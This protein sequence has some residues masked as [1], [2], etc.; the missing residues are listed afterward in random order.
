MRKVLRSL[1]IIVLL[2]VLSAGSALAGGVIK[3]GA[4]VGGQVEIQ[5][6]VLGIVI[7][8]EKN[9]TETGISIGGEYFFDMNESLVVG[10]GVEYQLKRKNEGAEKGF[11]FVPLYVLGR[12]N[13]SPSFYFTGKVGYNLFQAEDLPEELKTKGG[14]F[15]GFGG[16]IIFADTLQLEILYSMNN[17]KIVLDEDIGVNYELIWNYSKIGVSIGYK[18]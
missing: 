12:Y 1:T 9:D 14:L 3:V 4:D 5:G 10:V 17:G 8:E 7:L 16:G 13:V 15:Y 2:L 6:K 11:N 18:F